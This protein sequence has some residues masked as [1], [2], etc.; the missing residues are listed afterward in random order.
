M[1]EN[2]DDKYKGDS[3]GVVAHLFSMMPRMTAGI[4]KRK[5]Q[6]KKESPS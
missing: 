6:T 5:R 1:A 2:Q 4:R 3:Q